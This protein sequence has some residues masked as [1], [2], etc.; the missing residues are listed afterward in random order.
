M[1]NFCHRFHACILMN[2]LFLGRRGSD[3][4][5]FALPRHVMSTTYSG[6]VPGKHASC[7]DTRSWKALQKTGPKKV[8]PSGL[9]Q[10]MFAFFKRPAH[11]VE[12][13]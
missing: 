8:L 11:P 5:G 7:Q 9:V 2:R 10:W 13:C 4:S 6:H 1:Q 3:I 12:P